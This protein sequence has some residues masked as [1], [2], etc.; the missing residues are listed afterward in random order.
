MNWITGIMVPISLF[1]YMSCLIKDETFFFVIDILYRGFSEWD[2][3]QN[4]KN[5]TVC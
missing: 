4:L 2:N 3:K 1:S 5:G